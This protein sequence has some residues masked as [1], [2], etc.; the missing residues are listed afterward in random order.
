MKATLHRS[1]KTGGTTVGSARSHYPDVL[2]IG[3]PLRTLAA[4]NDSHAIMPHLSRER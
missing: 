3:I 1:N 4:D 2:R